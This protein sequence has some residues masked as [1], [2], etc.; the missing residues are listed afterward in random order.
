MLHFDKKKHGTLLQ[1]AHL[2]VETAELQKNFIPKFIKIIEN[3]NRRIG[4]YKLIFKEG[5]WYLGNLQISGLYRNKGI[6]TKIMALLESTVKRRGHHSIKLTAFYNNP[7]INLYKRMGYK[8]LEKQK[9][10][11]LMIKKF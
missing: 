9:E 8:I 3:N 7:A 11:Y 10:S 5:G 2:G 1:E 6:G 4:F